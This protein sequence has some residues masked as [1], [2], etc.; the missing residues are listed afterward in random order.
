[1]SKY[2][3]NRLQKGSEKDT[4]ITFSLIKV[5]SADV[6]LCSTAA[7]KEF[8]KGLYTAIKFSYDADTYMTKNKQFSVRSMQN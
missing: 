4:D 1:M 5:P 8:E 2:I 7:S 3:R 6:R